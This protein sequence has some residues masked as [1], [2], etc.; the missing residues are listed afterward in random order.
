MA[1]FR[2]VAITTTGEKITG[3]LQGETQGEILAWLREKSHTPVTLD[4]IAIGSGEQKK[5]SRRFYIRSSD[6]A[7]FCWQLNTMIDGGVP[8]TDAIDT[9]NEDI[10]NLKLQQVLGEVSGAMKTGQSFYESLEGYPKVFNDFFRAMIQAGE[11]SG[12]LSIVL[13]RLADYYDRKDE[14]QGKVKKAVAYPTF[15]VG[16]VAFI[17]VI[18]M[19]FIIPRF[20]EIFDSFGSE[21]PAFTRNFLNGYNFIMH[22]AHYL[23]GSLAATVTVLVLYNRTA[24]GHR[25][26]S[27]LWLRVPLMGKIIL[28]AFVATYGRAM[29]TLLSAGVPVL[30]AIEIVQGM[31]RNDIIRDTLARTREQIAEG[32]GIALSMSGNKVFP[33]LMVKMTQV[34]E[35]SGSLP[36]V[37]DRCSNYYEK[38]VDVVVMT[39]ISVLEPAMIVIVG[40]IVCTVLLALY[41]PIFSMGEGVSNAA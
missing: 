7:S 2:Y 5:A 24:R 16:F 15:V 29:A 35:E 14:L 30:D 39:M 36:Q 17:I 20:V 10:G 8:I 25:S 1:T 22:N 31:S 12:T 21:L 13:G 4:E 18:M 40:G 38:Q 3:T 6:M 41:M 37:L 33:S 23:L 27:T 19:T 28:A 9:I 11:L 32:A 26:F 34:G